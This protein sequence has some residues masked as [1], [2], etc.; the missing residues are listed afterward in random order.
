M[1]CP[2]GEKF[3]FRL[4]TPGEVY[5]LGIDDGAG[6]TIAAEGGVVDC[7]T[8]ASWKNSDD[9][10]VM[11]IVNDHFKNSVGLSAMFD[12]DMITEMFQFEFDLEC[13]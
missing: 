4:V 3:F 2:V 6:N 8:I 5:T 10:I 11:K 1:P 7:E 9:K 13:R 12:F